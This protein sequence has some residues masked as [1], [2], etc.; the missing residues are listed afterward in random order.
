MSTNPPQ[1]RLVHNLVH[2]N[3]TIW[4]H[5]HLVHNLRITDPDVLSWKSEFQTMLWYMLT[6][7]DDSW[8][9]KDLM[10]S[11]VDVWVVST[12]TQRNPKPDHPTVGF[13]GI[14]E[15]CILHKKKP[16]RKKISPH[17]SSFFKINEFFHWPRDCASGC[18]TILIMSRRSLPSR[19]WI[20]LALR[21]DRHYH[22]KFP[23]YRSPLQCQQHFT[24]ARLMTWELLREKIQHTYVR[25]FQDLWRVSRS[26]DCSPGRRCTT[27]IDKKGEII[28]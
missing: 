19:K 10:I 16:P 5:K 1:H 8:E 28:I 20:E 17:L 23:L 3:N 6:Q 15:N 4:L 11:R 2:Y 12:C 14:C 24:R 9:K 21:V 18:R 27:H 13:W 7:C 22:S 25:N 26:C